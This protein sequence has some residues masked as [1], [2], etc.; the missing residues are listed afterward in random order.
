[1]RLYVMR[2]G[3]AEDRAPS[4]RDFDRLLT[5]SGRELVR[6]VARAFQSARAA[7]QA[8]ASPLR[9]LASPR[10]RARET[11]AI[12]RDAIV[13]VPREI[14]L[15]DELGGEAAIPL[16]LI[17]AATASGVDT[18]LVGHQP[19]VEDLVRQLLGGPAGLAGF[20]TATVVGLDFAADSGAWTRALHL[21]PSRLPG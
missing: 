14:E 19:V 15:H 18:L 7:G 11:A 5:P 17:A 12:V 10:A 2:H 13:P 8:P 20:S 6:R 3:P 1:M 16:S 21:D 4:G 9:I